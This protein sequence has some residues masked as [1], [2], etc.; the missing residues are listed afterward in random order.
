MGLA[1]DLK[2]MRAAQSSADGGSLKAKAAKRSDAQTP[3]R[4]AIQAAERPAL[5]LQGTAKSK[6]P[7]FEKSTIYVRSATRKAAFRKWEDRQGGDFSD[8]VQK[9]LEDYANA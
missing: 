2:A 3:K 7:E 5:A 6:H 9:L 1:D 8:L 4:P